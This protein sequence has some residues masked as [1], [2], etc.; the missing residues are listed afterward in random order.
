MRLFPGQQLLREIIYVACGGLVV[1]VCLAVSTRMSA[2]RTM[3]RGSDP[4][5]K[6]RVGARFA[7][8][9]PSRPP[10][11]TIV[12]A[13]SDTCSHSV[14]AATF[15]Q[16]LVFKAKSSG[17]NVILIESPTSVR[18]KAWSSLQGVTAKQCDLRALNIMATPTVL[19]LDR[20][21]RIA[22]L[23]VGRLSSE[24]ENEVLR[25]LS[26]TEAELG[27]PARGEVVLDVR[28]RED[29]AASH[30]IG[31]L[32]IP[33]DELSV[34]FKHELFE[35]AQVMLDCSFLSRRMCQQAETALRRLGVPNVV[36]ANSGIYGVSC[37]RC[38]TSKSMSSP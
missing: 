30:S 11:W 19:L 32:N 35:A 13:V 38:T 28:Q 31:S 16:Q 27:Q 7:L 17:M 24:E 20:D 22:G 12:I 8:E 33:I 26:R 15:H 36:I 29:F 1:A 23:W 5:R 9:V 37:E 2:P 18:N 6:L 34:R 14:N 3:D 4:E 10:A 21:W 25:G